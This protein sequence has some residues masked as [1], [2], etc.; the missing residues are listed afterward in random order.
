M[1]QRPV[2]IMERD[3][4]PIRLQGLSKVY[5]YLETDDDYYNKLKNF[6]LK[7]IDESNGGN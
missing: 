1:T 6:I 2:K 7:D 3:G 5:Q 4:K